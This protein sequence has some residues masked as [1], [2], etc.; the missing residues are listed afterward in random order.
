MEGTRKSLITR[1]VIFYRVR[2]CRVRIFAF[3]YG[4]QWCHTVVSTVK[5]H[6][7]RYLPLSIWELS[8]GNVF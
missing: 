3:K 7:R 6:N 4:Q 1:T 8:Y 2:D 5:L